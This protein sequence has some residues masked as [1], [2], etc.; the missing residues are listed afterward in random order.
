MPS[1]FQA[2]KKCPDCGQWSDWNMEVTDTCQHCGALLSDRTSLNAASRE[3]EENKEA[4]HIG[5]IQIH[6]A[7]SWLVV[8]VK[9]MV[10]AL[11]ISFVAI[12]SFIIW[13]LTLLAG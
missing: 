3:A 7:D 10:Q 13:F 1:T 4:F 8:A 9:R 5:L 6:P 11:Q 2:S 12:V